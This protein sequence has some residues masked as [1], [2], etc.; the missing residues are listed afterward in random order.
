MR[1]TMSAGVLTAVRFHDEGGTGVS[2][3]PRMTNRQVEDAALAAV[4]EHERRADREARD[5]RGTGAAA[6]LI[7]GDRV[8]EVKAFGGSA[9]GQDLW[10]E[11]RQVEEADAN[12]SFWLYVVEH[13][14][15]G[16][17]ATTVL[18]VGGEQLAALLSCKR[19]QRYFTVPVPV[20]VYDELHRP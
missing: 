7:S 9:R 17:D 19:E 16:A 2:E 6:D 4:V 15:D 11:P 20:G 8:I 3:S 18:E 1:G 12:P 14:R 13:V 5:T 10:L